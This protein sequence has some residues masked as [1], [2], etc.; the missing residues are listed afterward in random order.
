[1]SK[2]RKV[3]VRDMELI[4]TCWDVNIVLNE[5]IKR[6]VEELI[7]TCWDVNCENVQAF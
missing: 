6:R 7:D 4:D 2:G 3:I 1:M 5:Y